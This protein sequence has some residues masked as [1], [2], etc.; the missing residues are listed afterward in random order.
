MVLQLRERPL[1]L[2]FRWVEF[3][4]VPDDV[5]RQEVYLQL[6]QKLGKQA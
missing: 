2:T 5:I 1:L 4:R 6:D 3:I